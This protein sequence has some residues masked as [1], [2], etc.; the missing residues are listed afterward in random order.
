MESRSD[1]AVVA[2]NQ[3]FVII[4]VWI[5]GRTEHRDGVKLGRKPS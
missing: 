2:P 5:V 4:G 3:R 1:S